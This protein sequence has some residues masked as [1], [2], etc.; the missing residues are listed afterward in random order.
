VAQR[1]ERDV[2]TMSETAG[3]ITEISGWVV[4]A[5]AEAPLSLRELVLVGEE[6]LIGEVV[7]LDR[8]EATIQVYEETEGVAPGAPLFATGQPLTVELGPGLLGGIFDGIQRPLRALA[9]LEGDFIGRGQQ[10]TSLDREKLWDFVPSIEAGREVHEGD[11]VGSVMETAALVHPIVVPPG[12]SGTVAWLAPRGPRRVLDPIVRFEDGRELTM[13]QKWRVRFPRPVRER[14]LSDEPLITGQRVLDT[15]FPLPKGGAAAMPG[16]FGTGK[17]VTQH[18]LCRWADA[19][20]ILFVGCGER[21]NEITQLIDELPRLA[22]PRTKRLLS[23]R[24]ILIANTSNMP[25][26]AREASLFTGI[27]IGEYYRDLGHDVLLLADSISRWAEALREISGRL[28]EMPAEEGYPPYLSSAL[29]A[30]FE[31]AGRVVTLSRTQGSLTIITAISPQAGDLT[32]PVT[33]HASRFVRTFWT[34]DRQLAAARVFPAV[35]MRA[36]YSEVA[37]GVT[38]WWTEHVSPQWSATREQMMK[39]LEEAA[40][41]EETARLVGIDSLPDRERFVLRLADRFQEEFLRQNAFDDDAYCA[42]ARQMEMLESFRT[43]LAE[44]PR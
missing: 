40:A 23:E 7:A 3:R 27:T 6:R 5:A 15:F 38:R 34:L 29:A 25:V 31:R 30:F 39:F 33:R 44:A 41:I 24:S 20:V 36:S 13:L 35:S 8:H 10:L 17:T 42:P 4:R 19:D 18:Q 9:D 14:L 21:G 11:V 26:S 37:P 1:I 16:G 28:G 2:Q 12:A 32:E 43:A 22:D